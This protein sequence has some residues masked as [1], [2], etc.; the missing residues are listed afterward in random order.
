MQAG[1]EEGPPRWRAQYWDIGA[2]HT[3]EPALAEFVDEMAGQIVEAYFSDLSIVLGSAPKISV[4]IMPN[5]TERLPEM[6]VDITEL[7]KDLV[8]FYDAD[9]PDIAAW[10]AVFERAAAELRR[11]EATAKSSQLL[12]DLRQLGAHDARHAYPADPSDP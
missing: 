4:V 3:T 5:G 9:H 2:D 6:G 7:T 12:Q 11:F 1:D 10:A 8:D